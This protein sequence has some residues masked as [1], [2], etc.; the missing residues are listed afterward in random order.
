MI[1]Q[2]KGKKDESFVAPSTS[3]KIELLIFLI[4][5][6]DVGD[7]FLLNPKLFIAIRGSQLTFKIFLAWL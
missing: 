1:R 3:I 4:L 6:V 7:F 5:K 2:V